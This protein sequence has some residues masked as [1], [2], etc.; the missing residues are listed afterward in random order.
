MLEL[1][2]QFDLNHERDCGRQAGNSDTCRF[3]DPLIILHCH[4]DAPAGV[5]I[6]W[7]KAIVPG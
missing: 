1:E 7:G 2:I 4:R 6:V 3:S 5:C